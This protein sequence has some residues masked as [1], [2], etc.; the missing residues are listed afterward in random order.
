[1]C[2]ALKAIFDHGLKRSSLLGSTCHPW[3]FLEEVR[4][5]LL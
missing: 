3:L 1:L 5:Y 4:L 2:P